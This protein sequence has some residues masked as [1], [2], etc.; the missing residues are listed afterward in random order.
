MGMVPGKKLQELSPANPPVQY[1]VGSREDEVRN[2]CKIAGVVGEML[3]DWSEGADK[4]MNRYL[5]IIPLS[6]CYLLTLNSPTQYQVVVLRS[7][8]C[9]CCASMGIHVQSTPYMYE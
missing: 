1:G 5:G 8:C 2:T 7:G 4:A 3:D 9:G 6:P